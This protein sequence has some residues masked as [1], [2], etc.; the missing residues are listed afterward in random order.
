MINAKD[1]LTSKQIKSKLNNSLTHNLPTNNKIK[2]EK[3]YL[4]AGPHIKV[5]TAARAETTLKCMM[6]IAMC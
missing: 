5:D 3:D 6:N 2:Q 4:I 1:K